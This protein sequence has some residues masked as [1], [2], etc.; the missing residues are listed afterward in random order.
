[1]EKTY[2][3]KRLEK[4]HYPWAK[5]ATHFYE[6]DNCDVWIA[7]FQS[8]GMV[9]HCTDIPDR[10]FS[11]TKNQALQWKEHILTEA[12][13]YNRPCVIGDSIMNRAEALWLVAVIEGSG[14]F[15]K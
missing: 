5:N 12:L 10:V 8:S 11:M 3:G 14:S 13:P 9:V 6:T 2:I 7:D 1:M 15:L 4:I